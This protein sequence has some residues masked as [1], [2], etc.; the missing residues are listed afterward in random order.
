VKA[1]ASAIT[2]DGDEKHIRESCL[3]WLV[4]FESDDVEKAVSLL[5]EAGAGSTGAEYTTWNHPSL[6]YL[7][8]SQRELHSIA[9]FGSTT[10][11]LW[12]SCVKFG[13][14]M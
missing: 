11:K 2:R 10:A 14:I 9:Q 3:Y 8:S 6:D 13:P 12:S 1:G 4:S 5:F 7:V